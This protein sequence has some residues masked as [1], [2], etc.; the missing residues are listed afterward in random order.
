MV[1]AAFRLEEDAREIFRSALEGV[2]PE[3]LIDAAVSRHDLEHQISSAGR[4]VL[5]ACGKAACGMSERLLHH[6]KITEGLVTVPHGGACRLPAGIEVITSAHPV[7]DRSSENAARRALALAQ[8]LG[9]GEIALVLISGG[10]SSLW[11]GVPPDLE[12]EHKQ[13]TVRELLRSGASIDE[14]NAVRKHLSTIKGGR[15]AR[16]AHPGRCISLII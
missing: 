8:S 5:L 9:E 15:L 12:L 11:A 3:R 16:A 4:A 2:S 1:A 10:G 6:V 14:I 13:D 7:P